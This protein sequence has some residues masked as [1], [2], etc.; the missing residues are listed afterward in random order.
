M[1]TK[2]SGS[3]D[4]CAP[5][6][7]AFTLI[8]LLVVIAIIALLI[9]I[10]LPSLEAARRASKKAACMASIKN[11]ATSSRVYEAD[12]PSGWGIPVHP[13]QYAQDPENPTFVGAYEWGGKSG[14]GAE[15]FAEQGQGILS[16][17]YGTSAGFGPASRP[18]N[19]ILYPAGFQD[20]KYPTFRRTGAKDDTE[21]NLDI[22]KCP[23]D[24]GPPRG[25]HCPDWLAESERSSYDHF[26]NSY[27]ANMFMTAQSGGSNPMRSNSPYLRPITRV[28]SP[29]R[30]LYYEEN[31]GRWAYAA[32]NEWCDFLTGIDMGPT[33]TIRGWHGPDWSYNRAF[34]DAHAE[35][36][37]IF[38]EGTEDAEGYSDH[39][40]SER[41]SSYPPRTD[42]NC[43]PIEG[44]TYLYYRCV[45]IRGPGWAKDTLPA[46]PICT[47]LL[48]PGT[49]RPSYEG[50][51]EQ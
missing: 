37:R 1:L 6:R 32:R 38:V 15:G 47:G 9:S 21:L 30:A 44:G 25:G 10:L 49:G 48:S 2:V 8:E 18:M 20:N 46:A 4:R 34:V 24:D 7:G 51:V 22:F 3:R 41:L 42:I 28:P 29:S 35:F 11:I 13:L 14:I 16:S 31:I 5:K 50:C 12:D 19:D 36:Q 40:V 26:G 17:K 45:I 39:Y 33:K 43:H 27:T 23:G